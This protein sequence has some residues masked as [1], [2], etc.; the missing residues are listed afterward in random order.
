MCIWPFINE[1]K[2]M[3][4][5]FTSVLCTLSGFSFSMVQSTINPKFWFLRECGCYFVCT[6]YI[7]NASRGSSKGETG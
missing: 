6:I 1:C 3:Q 5:E 2:E 7:V 4:K